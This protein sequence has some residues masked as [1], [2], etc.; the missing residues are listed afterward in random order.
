MLSAC[1]S[2]A[3]A[4]TKCKKQLFMHQNRLAFVAIVAPDARFAKKRVQQKR[5][6]SR[7]ANETRGGAAHRLKVA[8]LVMKK[9]PRCGQHPPPSS[10]TPPVFRGSAHFRGFWGDSGHFSR[11]TPPVGPDFPFRGGF[12]GKMGC[13]LAPTPHFSLYLARVGVP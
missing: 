4:R 5:C 13:F 12:P 6:D 2:C 1:L 10:G 3:P 9:K 11:Q 7:K 8:L